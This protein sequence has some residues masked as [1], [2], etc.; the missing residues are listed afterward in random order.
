MDAGFE[1]GSESGCS[2]EQM[3][4]QKT[5]PDMVVAT[6]MAKARRFTIWLYRNPCG[7]NGFVSPAA[8][9]FLAAWAK[10]WDGLAW[11]C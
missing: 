6:I 5:L 2:G 9:I 10:L 11:L 1:C 3:N 7:R 8:G 4:P